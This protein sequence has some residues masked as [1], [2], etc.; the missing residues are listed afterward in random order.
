[1]EYTTEEITELK[2]KMASVGSY[3]PKEL[4]GYVWNNYKKISGS[5][6]PQPCNCPSSGNL[7]RKALTTINEFL[8][9]NE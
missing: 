3:L 4:T 5:K 8:T 7:W 1:M 6:E 2:Q 9:K